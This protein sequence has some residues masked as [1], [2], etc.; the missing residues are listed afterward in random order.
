MQPDAAADKRQ[1]Q[2]EYHKIDSDGEL[3]LDIVEANF[4]PSLVDEAPIPDCAD[5]CSPTVGGAFQYGGNSGNL[6]AV[7]LLEPDLEDPVDNLVGCITADRDDG[8]GEDCAELCDHNTL[9]A[10]AMR[11][12]ELSE[13]DDR[14]ES[15]LALLQT[16]NPH[17]FV[18]QHLVGDEVTPSLS[19]DDRCS[20]GLGPCTDHYIYGFGRDGENFVT[21]H[22]GGDEVAHQMIRATP[23]LYHDPG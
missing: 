16:G 14:C 7:D 1:S 10:T 8:M 4:M 18:T 15:F 22:A 9:V 17:N 23:R 5:T 13:W 3:E 2:T 20:R 11:L 12:K 21:T 6:A 19:V